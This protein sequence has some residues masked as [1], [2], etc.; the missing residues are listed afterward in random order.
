MLE[1]GGDCCLAQHRGSFSFVLVQQP[2]HINQ[3]YGEAE[4]KIDEE[5]MRSLSSL[6]L[7][8]PPSG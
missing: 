2:D 6:L 4:G 8:P 3:A 7:P 5:A 1:M